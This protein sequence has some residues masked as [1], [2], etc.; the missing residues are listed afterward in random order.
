MRLKEDNSSWNASNV[1]RKVAQLPDEPVRRS[2]KNTRR[3][4]KG[5][6]GVEH[7]Y[8][9]NV[10]PWIGTLKQRLKVCVNCG[11]QDYRTMDYKFLERQR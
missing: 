7:D 8:Q 5:R 10:L 3:W 2:K 11:K 9:W 6:V 4:C 1:K